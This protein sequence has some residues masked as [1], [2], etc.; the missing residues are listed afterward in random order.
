MP[1]ISSRARRIP[2]GVLP[3][4]VR[5]LAPGVGQNAFFLKKNYIDHFCFIKAITGLKV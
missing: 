3:L 4:T 1:I 2:D 5:R